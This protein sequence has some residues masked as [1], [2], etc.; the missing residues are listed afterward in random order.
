MLKAEFRAML[1]CL[2]LHHGANSQSTR[3]PAPS[4]PAAPR[5]CPLPSG[6]G[7]LLRPHVVCGPPSLHMVPD[8]RVADTCLSAGSSRPSRPSPS[9][10]LF[11]PPQALGLTV[12]RFI[13]I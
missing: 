5:R 10:T 4:L 6:L 1:L 9:P 2:Q 8:H 13:F 12:A 7:K 3:A 11:V